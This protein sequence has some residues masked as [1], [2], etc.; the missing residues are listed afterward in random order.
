MTCVTVCNLYYP[1]DGGGVV[2]IVD[3]IN[4]EAVF[5]CLT[6]CD[7]WYVPSLTLHGI[8]WSFSKTDKV[9]KVQRYQYVACTFKLHIG[10]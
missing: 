3:T 5:S 8:G 1:P 10:N 4:H 6:L 9:S 7:G 2:L